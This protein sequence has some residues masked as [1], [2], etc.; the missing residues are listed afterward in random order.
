MEILIKETKK[1]KKKKKNDFPRIGK[2]LINHWSPMKT[3]KSLP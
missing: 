1:K 2:S 3:E